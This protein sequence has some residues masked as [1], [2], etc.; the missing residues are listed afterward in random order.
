MFNNK[1][2]LILNVYMI[3]KYILILIYTNK[4]INIINF[5]IKYRKCPRGFVYRTSSNGYCQACEIG[6][7]M[8][9]NGTST[10]GRSNCFE[11]GQLGGITDGMISQMK[12]QPEY[13]RIY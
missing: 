2:Y 3:Y 10:T 1:L 9:W 12:G 6:F 11:C 5:V 13:I 4:N 7:Y 8:S